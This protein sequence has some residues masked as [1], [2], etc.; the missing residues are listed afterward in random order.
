MDV[1]PIQTINLE[2]ASASPL[3]F[4]SI[5]PNPTIADG[6]RIKIND[7][8]RLAFAS[9]PNVPVS[10]LCASLGVN[11]AAGGFPGHPTADRYALQL[12]RHS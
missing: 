6:T 7:K 10:M 8:G 5:L 9:T 3:D 1:V 11:P 4:S 12:H 2:V